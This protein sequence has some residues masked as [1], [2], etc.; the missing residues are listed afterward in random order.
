MHERKTGN[1]AGQPVAQRDV[2]FEHQSIVGRGAMP[3]KENFGGA[4]KRAAEGMR[5]AWQRL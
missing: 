2:T 1:G 5:S 3:V 4:Q